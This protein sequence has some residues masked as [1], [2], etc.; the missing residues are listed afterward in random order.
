MTR[1]SALICASFLTLAASAAHAGGGPDKYAVAVYHF[2]LQYVA[3][4]L[5][6]FWEDVG[7]PPAWEGLDITDE[8]VQDA[9]IVE[10]FVPLLELYAA[11]PEWGGDF[12]LQGLMVDVIA[13][14]HPD[15]LALMQELSDAG[16][17]SFDS[18]HYSDELWTAQ[19]V[20]AIQRSYRDTVEAFDRHGIT[21][22]QSFFTQ[23]G[24]FAP[25]MAAV[26]P[27]GSVAMI[28]RNLFGLHYPDSERQPLYTLGDGRYATIGGHSW[29]TDSV[30][31]S[32]TFMDDGELLATG[33]IPPYLYPAFVHDPAEVA[34]Y[35]QRLLDLEAEGYAI[36]SVEAAMDALL[37]SGFAPE[38]L[39]PFID[40]AWQPDDTANVGLWMGDGG[41]WADDEADGAVRAGYHRAFRDVRIAE[42]IVGEDDPAVR[43]GWTELALGGVSDSTG[44]N[45]YR[46]EVTY[47]LDHQA[48]AREAVA[49]ILAA[50]QLTLTGAGC[51]IGRLS[52]DDG[53]AACAV[54]AA[55]RRTEADAQDDLLTVLPGATTAE[56]AWFEDDAYPGATGVAV[57]FSGIRLAADPERAI[58][59][60]S[61]A[62]SVRILS[63]GQSETLSDVPL[64]LFDEEIPIAVPLAG[65]L[66]HLG[67]DLWLVPDP[68]TTHLG[69]RVHPD[70]GVVRFHDETAGL[71]D[72]ETW[73]LYF[74]EGEDA[75][76]TL[77]DRLTNRPPLEFDV[78]FPD[79]ILPEVDC[80]CAAA[81]GAAPVL[82]ALL[83]GAAFSRRRRRSPPGTPS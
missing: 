29:A 25:G 50:Q 72:V 7:E 5:E 44:W 37:A 76:R 6:A 27:E 38:P 1:S 41:G 26:I 73:E 16:N 4:G 28:P 10:S 80:S 52:G 18:F 24:Q 9:I 30:Q 78:A 20:Q 39:P 51:P 58:E 32:W 17:V 74:V 66:L 40:G 54:A 45:P 34:E 81:P 63:A 33:D 71:E 49:T 3:G 8:G 35:E 65:G 82:P 57:T 12:E 22:A 13:E 62:E 60:A 47:G 48:A 15:V 67:D 59:I 70:S 43:L 23:E 56:A 42:L 31:V 64:E 68:Q 19:P 55:D 2:N 46:T 77:A 83:L 14:R 11:H 69:A 75:A 53:S 79:G 36:V 61:T 21:H